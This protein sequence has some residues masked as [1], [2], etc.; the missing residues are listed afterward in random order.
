MN[1]LKQLLDD[2]ALTPYWMIVVWIL[3][4]WP[5]IMFRHRIQKMPKAGTGSGDGIGNGQTIGAREE[6]DD[7][8]ATVNMPFGLLAV[9]ADGISGLSGGRVAST[10]AVHTFVKEF[11]ELERFP[12]PPEFFG[13]AAM[14]ANGEIMNQLHGVQGG[15]TLV[16]A[17][18]RSSMLY[19][20]AVGDSL[21][22]VYRGGILIPVNHKHT[23]ENTLQEQYL[24]GEITESEALGNPQRKT[25]VNYLGSE[26]F[27]SME[28]AEEPFQLYKG[29][30]IMLCSDGVYNTL[31]EMEMETIL[32]RPLSPYEAAQA[33]IDLIEEKRLVHQDNATVIIVERRW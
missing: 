31:T 19:W 32:S 13:D 1:T 8:F 25:L 18:I 15:T 17:L 5:L 14:N 30:K 10:A 4:I 28:L 16:A 2:S 23:L 29:D 26:N 3:L 24:S 9:L 22:F 20:G 21:L 27:R 7:Y 6:Q 11:R 33:M 12:D